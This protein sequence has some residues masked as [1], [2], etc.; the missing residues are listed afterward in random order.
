[1]AIKKL[2]AGALVLVALSVIVLMG[3]AVTGGVSDSLR[4]STATQRNITLLNGTAVTLTDTWVTAVT[5]IANATD[6][7]VV[8]TGN[9][10]ATLTTNEDTAGAVTLTTASPW[11]NTLVTVNYTYEAAS[12]G[13]NAA[14][15]F[16]TGLAVFAT[17]TAIVALALVGKAIIG[18]FRKNKGYE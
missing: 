10:T 11:N 14:D 13:S 15:N 6:G 8:G 17:F 2:T 9:Y 4:D 7:T 16:T 1:M 5:G 12:T 18:Y 3:M